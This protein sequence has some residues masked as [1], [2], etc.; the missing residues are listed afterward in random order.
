MYYDTEYKENTLYGV[1]IFSLLYDDD[2]DDDGDDE[3]PA[4][5]N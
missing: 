5:L 1:L 3:H 2:D 4:Q